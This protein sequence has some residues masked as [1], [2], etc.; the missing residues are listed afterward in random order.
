MSVTREAFV[1]PLLFL[2]VALL[3]GLRIDARVPLVHLVP[4]SLMALVLG[5][6]LVGAVVRGR[7]VEPQFLLSAGRTPLE[8]ISGGIVLITLL[9]ASAQIFNLVTPER[10]LFHVVFTVFFLVQLLTT[11]AGGNTRVSL[12]RSLFVLLAS[13]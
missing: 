11:L 12:L 1:L 2:T 7:G 3:G 9:A 8:N 10:G 5:T 6:L 13:G 4:P